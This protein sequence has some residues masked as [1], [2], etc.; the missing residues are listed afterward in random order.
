MNLGVFLPRLK[1]VFDE[2]QHPFLIKTLQKVGVEGTYLEIVKAM[3]DKPMANIVLNGEKLKS[4]I[5]RSGPRQGCAHSPLLFKIV[6]EVLGTII[7]EKKKRNK[8]NPDWK[9]SKTIT[10]CKRHDTIP[11]KS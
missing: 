4:F 10:V 5:I 1:R 2:I 11:R 8:R 9:R 6:L 7:R 3:C